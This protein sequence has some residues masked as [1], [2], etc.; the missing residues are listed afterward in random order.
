[1]A[2]ESFESKKNEFNFEQGLDI[3]GQNDKYFK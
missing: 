2:Q 3:D 1:M